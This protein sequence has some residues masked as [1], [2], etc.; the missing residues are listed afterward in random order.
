MCNAQKN[1]A[2]LYAIQFLTSL[3]QNYAVVKSQVLLMDHLPHMNK[4][5][6]M[7]LQHERQGNFHA[8]ED[9]ISLVNVVDSQR[10]KEKSH[11]SYSFGKKTNCVCT[12]Y[13]KTN[14][15]I[16]NCYAKHGFPPHMQRKFANHYSI[17]DQEVDNASQVSDAKF[18]SPYI[19]FEQYVS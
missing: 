19:T 4:I 15:T 7:V 8:S 10:F 17:N 16:D 11:G 6:S 5:F 1:H 18:V 14:H 12:H 13:G 9:L 3:N 2:T